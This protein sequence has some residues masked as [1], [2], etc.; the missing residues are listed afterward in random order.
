MGPHVILPPSYDVDD[1]PM[2]TS[3]ILFPVFYLA[4][5]FFFLKSWLLTLSFLVTPIKTL[6]IALSVTLNFFSSLL[7]VVQVS[8]S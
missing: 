8:A 2:S 6:S 5:L 4:L 1:Q 7:V 3:L